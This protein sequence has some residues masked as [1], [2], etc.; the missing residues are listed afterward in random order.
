MATAVTRQRDEFH[1]AFKRELDTYIGKLEQP[2]RGEKKD[3]A[4]LKKLRIAAE[5]MAEN[6]GRR[7][8]AYAQAFDLDAPAAEMHDSCAAPRCGNAPPCHRLGDLEAELHQRS[9]EEDRLRSELVERKKAAVEEGLRQ[10]NVD[11]LRARQAALSTELAIDS[12][13]SETKAD[14]LVRQLDQIEKLVSATNSLAST[15]DQDRENNRLIEEQRRRPLHYM[16]AEL[17]ASVGQNVLVSCGMEGEEDESQ[18]LSADLERSRKVCRRMQ[19]QFHDD[20]A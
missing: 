17:L 19:Q 14:Q 20:F 8:T 5:S 7:M 1:T 4:R 13:A 12:E 6:I 15:L 11:L 18:Q 9:I 10:S 16:E 2:H 3:P